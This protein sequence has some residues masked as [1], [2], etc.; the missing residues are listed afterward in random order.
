MVCYVMRK[1]YVI[2]TTIDN[3]P[4]PERADKVQFLANDV[5]VDKI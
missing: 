4:P 3:F 5:V 2:V 1:C